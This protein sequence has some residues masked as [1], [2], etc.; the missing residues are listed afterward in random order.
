PGRHLILIFCFI[1]F[2]C[3]I[4]RPQSPG[5]REAVIAKNIKPLSI[6]DQIPDELWNMP[7]QVV[8]HPEGKKTI[9]L[10]QYKGKLIILDFWATWCPSSIKSLYKLDSIQKESKKDLVVIPITNDKPQKADAFFKG[11]KWNLPSVVNDSSLQK[12]FPHKYIPHYI[13]VNKERTIEAIT[14]HDPVNRENIQAI[15]KGEKTKMPFKNDLLDFDPK[16][17][18]FIDGNGGDGS[19]IKYRSL[20]SEP[21]SGLFQTTSSV[22]S[23][24]ITNTSRIYGI[25]CQVLMLYTLAYKKIESFPG[26]RIKYE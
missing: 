14:G 16:K 5:N 25:N 6:G 12:Y 9:T 22:I 2:S 3:G 13:W 11:R 26:N 19:S 20:F 1:M 10:S 15:I 18:L 8:N 23:D 17:P 21:I 7:L 24:T 4:A